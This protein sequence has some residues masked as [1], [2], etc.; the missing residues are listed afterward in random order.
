MRCN[1]QARPFSMRLHKN[2]YSPVE[3][4]LI[5]CEQSV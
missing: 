2:Q 3:Q 1:G 4:K 5:L